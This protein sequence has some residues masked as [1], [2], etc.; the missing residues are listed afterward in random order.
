M[1]SADYKKYAD[2]QKEKA[3]RKATANKRAIKKTTKKTTQ[4]SVLLLLALPLILFYAVITVNEAVFRIKYIPSWF[5]I[6]SCIGSA[7]GSDNTKSINKADFGSVSLKDGE[8]TVYYFDVGQGDSALILT[9]KE[10]I[11]IDCGE[12]EYYGRVYNDLRNLGVTKLTAAIMSHPD[13]DHCGGFAN[14]I[15]AFQPTVFYMPELSAD[16]IPDTKVYSDIL[17]A[18]DDNDTKV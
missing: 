5:E 14:I 1:D 13:S 17:D 18:L 6:Y 16:A 4:R 8:V 7:T 9:N 15:N 2:R 3:T 11:L 12:K 10:S